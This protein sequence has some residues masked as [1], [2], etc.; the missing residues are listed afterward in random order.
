MSV[1]DVGCGTGRHS[2]ELATRGYL[3]TGLDISESMLE[4]ARQKADQAGVDVD[5]VHGNAK[6]FSFDAPFDA[7]ICLCEG[8]F[9]LLGSGDDPIEQ[10]LAILRCVHRALKP[11]AH[12]LFT[13]LNGYAIARRHANEDV[14]EGRFDPLG[15]TEISDVYDPNVHAGCTMK[16]RGFVPTELRLLFGVAGLDV[17][18][19]WGGTAGNW[20]ERPVDLDEIEIMVLAGKPFG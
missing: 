15:L 6:D 14:S 13:V 2:V 8:A 7:A 5:W 17:R 18:E 4:L 20:G 3:V 10:P 1:L 19:I 12:C 11:G 9:G 16:E